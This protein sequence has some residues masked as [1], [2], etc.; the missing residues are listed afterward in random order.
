MLEGKERVYV[1]PTDDLILIIE[2]C[3]LP[4]RIDNLQHAHA[5]A[6]SEVIGFVPGLVGAVVEYGRLGSKR[7]KCEEMPGREVENV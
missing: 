5:F 4:H 7:I 1:P 3:R 2:A 6:L